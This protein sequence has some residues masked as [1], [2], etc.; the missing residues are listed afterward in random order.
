VATLL[1][2]DVFLD[3]IVKEALRALPNYG[4]EVEFWYGGELVYTLN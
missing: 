3:F 1:L 2:F 4:V